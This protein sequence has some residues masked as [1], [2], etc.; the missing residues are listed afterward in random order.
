MAE[1]KRKIRLLKMKVII[2]KEEAEKLYAETGKFKYKILTEMVDWTTDPNY[3][4]N[5]LRRAEEE[6]NELRAFA[7]E[8]YPLGKCAKIVELFRVLKREEDTRHE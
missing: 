3:L 5:L 4:P 1:T 2:T 7:G 6:Y 8:Q